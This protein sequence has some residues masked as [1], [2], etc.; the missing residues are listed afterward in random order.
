M[1]SLAGMLKARG[2]HVTGSDQQVYPPMSTQLQSWGIPIYEGFDARHLMTRPDLVIV[3][4]AVS[5]DNAEAKA[6]RDANIPT[7]SFPQALAHFFIQDRHSIVVTGTH[8]KSTTTALIAWLLASAGYDPGVFVG[9]VMRNTDST[10]RLGNGQHFVV[11]GDEYDS[12]YFDKRPKFLHYRPRTAVLTSLEFDHADIYRDLAHVRSAFVEFLLRLPAEGCL[13][14]CSDQPNVREVLAT[15]S[16][17]VPVQTYGLEAGANW[18]AVMYQSDPQG[19]DIMVY[20]DTHLYGHIHTSLFGRHNI[21]NLLAAIAVAHH[22]GLTLDQITSGL[23]TYAHIKRRCEIRGTVNDITVIDDFAHHPTAVQMTLEAVRMIY[24]TQRLWAVFEPRTATSRR[25]IFQQDYQQAL[26][27]ADHILI[28]DVHRK[29]QLRPE[30]RL[31]PEALVQGLR[32]RDKD[33]WFFASTEAII[34]HLSRETQSSDI[35]IIMSNGG[36]ENIHDRLLIALSQRTV[37]SSADSHSTTK[38]PVPCPET[39]GML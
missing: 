10:F 19:M 8:G 25:N 33:A 6:T 17:R 4:N 36:F 31:S 37:T 34:N 15:T 29:A 35:I 13:I 18:Q 11:E 22:V 2:F 26:Q 39:K 16:M 14:A 30:E 38:K 23:S 9:A 21:Q 3:G 27:L 12:A 28:A 1:G 5:R 20:H 24:P 32:A 7:M